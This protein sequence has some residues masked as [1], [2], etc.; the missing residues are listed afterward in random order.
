M[1]ISKMEMQHSVGF[2]KSLHYGVLIFFIALIIIEII[3]QVYTER[4]ATPIVKNLGYRFLLVTNDLSTSSK[5]LVK[6]GVY[7]STPDFWSGIWGLLKVME[8]FFTSFYFVYIW[9]WLLTALF[10]FLFFNGN[11]N[12]SGFLLA[13]LFFFGLQAFFN[14]S[15]YGITK[16]IDCFSGCEKSVTT[17]ITTPILWTVDVF[18][19][20]LV[21]GEPSTE[22]LEKVN[23][24]NN[25]EFNYTLPFNMS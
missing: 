12:L 4:S 2:L 24:T 21:L 25:T 8:K 1:L 16:N 3:Y 23:P 7:S 14:V 17:Y 5:E 20:V 6:S 9:I 19:V 13:L 10:S 22:I 18:R 15:Y 11:K